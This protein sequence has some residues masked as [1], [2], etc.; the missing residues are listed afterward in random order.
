M[1]RTHKLDFILQSLLV[2][3]K[4]VKVHSWIFV[5][6]S[7]NLKDSC[8]EESGSSKRHEVLEGLDFIARSEDNAIENTIH[9]F[10]T[11]MKLLSINK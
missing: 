3:N 6:S 5:L 9:I 4:K 1:K 8:M 10:E 11:N 2:L 7:Y